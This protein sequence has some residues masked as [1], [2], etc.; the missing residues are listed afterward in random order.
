M[1]NRLTAAAGLLLTLLLALSF[2]SGCGGE[3]SPDGFV[4]SWQETGA[5]AAYKMQIA[6][7]EDGLF[8]VTYRRFYPNGARCEHPSC[9]K[10]RR[11]RAPT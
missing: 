11:T 2:A 6:A 3:A 10:S 9:T 5:S 8:T 4:G 7:S 1:V